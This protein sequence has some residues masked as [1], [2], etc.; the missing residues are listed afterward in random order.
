MSTITYLPLD[1]GASLSVASNLHSGPP[2]GR[3]AWPP[4]RGP[5]DDGAAAVALRSPWPQRL[6]GSATASPS[7]PTT[8]RTSAPPQGPRVRRDRLAGV[9]DF[10]ARHGIRLERTVRG[11]SWHAGAQEPGLGGEGRAARR[12]RRG[13]TLE[14][15]DRGPGCGSCGICSGI[16][17][18]A[19]VA[20]VV[21]TS[22][23]FG[24]A[25]ARAVRSSSAQPGWPRTGLWAR[26]RGLPSGPRGSAS[27]SAASLKGGASRPSAPGEAARVGPLG[28][29]GRHQRQQRAWTSPHAGALGTARSVSSSPRAG[30][31]L[32]DRVARWEKAA[33]LGLRRVAYHFARRRM[34]TVRPRRPATSPPS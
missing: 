18:R 19:A 6:R 16:S 7:R 12:K 28:A 5:P 15:G 4:E 21:R 10:A 31:D 33:A 26:G 3:V 22:G 14:P 27:A 9:I 2:L 30:L 25:T 23:R 32:R 29:V 11:E 17:G 34:G 8:P 13:D 20:A 24:P 1:G